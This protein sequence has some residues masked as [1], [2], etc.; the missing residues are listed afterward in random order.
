MDGMPF[1]TWPNEVKRLC[2]APGMAPTVLHKH[3][4][5]MPMQASQDM[6]NNLIYMLMSNVSKGS[7]LLICWQ[8]GLK[9]YEV[10]LTPT[11]T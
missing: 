8:N 11:F 1:C 6:A 10:C 7:C 4:H 9:Q 2:I 5:A 3:T